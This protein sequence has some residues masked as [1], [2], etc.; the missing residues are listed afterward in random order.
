MKVNID[1]YRQIW[2]VSARFRFA[3][4]AT[5]AE[6]MISAGS[7]SMPSFQHAFRM[8]SKSAKNPHDFR[9]KSAQRVCG[10]CRIHADFLR[11]CWFCRMQNFWKQHHVTWLSPIDFWFSIID[12]S[13][14]KVLRR[15]AL[16]PPRKQPRNHEFWPNLSRGLCPGVV[17][18]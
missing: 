14:G 3:D 17:S 1:L 2:K 6:I 12:A 18:E 7:A 16:T 9:T 11:T 5:R 15:R 13:D 10:T 4:S 8:I